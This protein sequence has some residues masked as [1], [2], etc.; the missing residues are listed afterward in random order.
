MAVIS[1]PNA[2]PNWPKRFDRQINYQPKYAHH[3]YET[4]LIFMR[5]QTVTDNAMHWPI[6]T[7]VQRRKELFKRKEMTENKKK[8]KHSVQIWWNGC[9][10][11]AI[12]TQFMDVLCIKRTAIGL[13]LSLSRASKRAHTHSNIDYQKTNKL[14]GEWGINW[15]SEICARHMSTNRE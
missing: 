11:N 15:P 2:H 4:M 10:E 13:S 12:E 3:L 14:S 5:L 8:T 7:S 6:E 9:N 1:E